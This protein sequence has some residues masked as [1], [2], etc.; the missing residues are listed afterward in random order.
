MFPGECVCG[1]VWPE[2]AI[3]RER[4]WLPEKCTCSAF[5]A[6]ECVCWAFEDERSNDDA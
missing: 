6:G 4:Q 3:E 1:A 5:F 2:E